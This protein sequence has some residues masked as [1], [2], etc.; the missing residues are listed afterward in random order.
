MA[1]AAIA[2]TIALVYAGLLLRHSPAI[3]LLFWLLYIV[4]SEPI[5]HGGAAFLLSAHEPSLFGRINFDGA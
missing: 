1:A 2:I 5:F 3:A 4:P